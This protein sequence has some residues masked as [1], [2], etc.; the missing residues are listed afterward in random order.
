EMKIDG[1]KEQQ[2]SDEIR[3]EATTQEKILYSGTL[4]HSLNNRN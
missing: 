3:N 4:K 1:T 2:A